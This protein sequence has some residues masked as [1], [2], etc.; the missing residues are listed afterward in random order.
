MVHTLIM[1]GGYMSASYMYNL[2]L[3]LSLLISLNLCQVFVIIAGSPLPYN[4]GSPFLAHLAK[5][6]VSF[7]HPSSVNFSHQVSDAGS[8]EP[9][10]GPSIDHG[11]YM[12][13]FLYMV[14]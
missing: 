8:G 7:W 9:L 2:N 14:I 11:R 3:I 1:E 10:V 4:L 12:Y 6:N 5:G 13:M